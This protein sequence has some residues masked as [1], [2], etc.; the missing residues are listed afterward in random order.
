[1]TRRPDG[2]TA[3]LRGT[4]LLAVPAR[5]GPDDALV[6]R[7]ASALRA[8]GADARVVTVGDAEVAGDEEATGG[9]GAAGDVGTASYDGIAAAVSALAADGGE[10]GGVLSLL[11]LT[12][13]DGPWAVRKVAVDTL[14]LLRAL[15]GADASVPVWSLTSGA[16]STGASE[17]V[18]G[19]AQAV[20]WGLGRLLAEDT[21]VRW[22]GVVDVPARCGDRVLRRLAEAL[23]SPAGETELA[24]R[25][26]GVF[27]RRLLKAATADGAAW[28]GPRHRTRAGRH[29][30]GERRHRH[31]AGPGGPQSAGLRCG[32]RPRGHR[33]GRAG[34]DGH[35]GT[36]RRRAHPRR[37]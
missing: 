22:A 4:W 23:V 2:A 30:C 33:A 24:V 26:A 29:A 27:A 25:D 10:L 7:L 28:P 3:R 15:S 36:R 19:S 20:L 34:A 13:A 17:R 35:A 21:E 31:L 9:S 16:V 18:T 11:G 37:L 1:M 12:A 14:A 32:T 5:L 6:T 8:V